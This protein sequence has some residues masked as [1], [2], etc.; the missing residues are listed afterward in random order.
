MR[1][2]A[3][4]GEEDGAEGGGLREEPRGS[5][6]PRGSRAEVIPDGRCSFLVVF[7]FFLFFLTYL[8]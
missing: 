6:L 4:A 3:H 1:G 5:K 8:A 7:V 2:E